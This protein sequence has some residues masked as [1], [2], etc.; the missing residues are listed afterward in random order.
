M[1]LVAVAAGLLVGFR[2]APDPVGDD[3]G[4]GCEGAVPVAAAKTYLE[5]DTIAVDQEQESSYE[6]DGRLSCTITPAVI[7]SEVDREADLL[8]SISTAQSADEYI[9]PETVDGESMPFG[10]GWIGNYGT[11]RFAPSVGIA[12]LLLECPEELGDGLMVSVAGNW[13]ED[14]RE[15]REQKHQQLAVV[16]ARVA[17]LVDQEWGC[18]GQTGR[19]PTS[20]PVPQNNPEPTPVEEA[21]GTCEGVLTAE[22]ARALGVEEVWETPADKNLVEECGFRT[23]NGSFD[24]AASYGPAGSYTREVPW[25]EDY[26]VTAT[27]TCPGAQGQAWYTA[28]TGDEDAAMTDNLAEIFDAFVQSSAAR[29]GCQIDESTQPPPADGAETDIELGAGELAAGDSADNALPPTEETVLAILPDAEAITDDGWE[30]EAPQTHTGDESA[31]C[32]EIP[33]LCAADQAHATVEA[34]RD[35]RLARFEVIAYQDPDAAEAAL[36]A[37][38]DYFEDF[39]QGGEDDYDHSGDLNHSA[40]LG[41]SI[42]DYTEVPDTFRTAHRTYLIQGPYLGIVRYLGTEYDDAYDRW[43]I[44]EERL[45]PLLS[46]RMNQAEAGEQPDASWPQD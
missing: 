3:L 22:Q 33:D 38:A 30:L 18:G 32:A 1:A 23:R 43:P 13:D 9:A 29:H 14:D 10:S 5:S 28:S 15:L 39:E 7:A 40:E 46:G 12:T 19:V 45:N 35:G 6:G 21:S 26:P 11:D 25:A 37:A 31:T 24:M 42:Q 27:A 16:A 36:E 41:F 34:T 17:L 20:I 2:L 4:D 44:M 8:I